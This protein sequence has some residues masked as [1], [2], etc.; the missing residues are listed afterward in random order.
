MKIAVNVQTLVDKQMEGLGWFTFESIKRITQQHLEHE[1]L[2]IFGKGI[3]KKFLFSDNITAIN[4]GP[5]FFRPLVWY[6][7]FE[8]LLP[9][10]LKKHKIDL[11]ISTDGISSTRLKGKILNVI[12]DLNFEENPQWLPKS[13]ANYYRK[14]FPLW[15]KKATRIAT[16]SEYSK[17]DIHKKYNIDLNKIDVV[18]NGSN[19]LYQPISDKQ[20]EET[21]T[22]YSRGQKYFLFVGSLHP[23]KNI[24]Q[25]LLSFGKFKET[26]TQDIKLVI[27]GNKFYWNGPIKEAF[28]SL[29]SKT[30]VIFTGHLSTDKLRNIVASSIALVYVSLFEGFGIPLVEAM[31]AETAIISSTA[32]CL[33]E[34][35]G[36][37][38]LY[39][40]PTST[41]EISDAM[42]QLCN[43][44][45]LREELIEK[46]R[47][48]R[49]LFSW[50]Q[51]ADKLWEAIE[52]TM[53]S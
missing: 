31:N 9:A 25:L 53:N 34:I 6:F 37:S 2:F 24:E 18:Y 11:F 35:A 48:Q 41:K 38:A 1:F 16:V 40:N 44:S 3:D 43:N 4:I 7:K 39:V 19:D 49:T 21:R 51:T 30:D 27:V 23:R 50:Q 5:P 8:Y 52:K 15:A 17:Q 36:E 33:P 42:H 29:K 28:D 10:I 26:D 12:H 47:K 13:F 14:Y 32:T 45:V 46:G 20:K 22:E